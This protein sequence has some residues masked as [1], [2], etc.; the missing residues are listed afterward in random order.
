MQPQFTRTCVWVKTQVM[1]VIVTIEGGFDV[2]SVNGA[3]GA[4]RRVSVLLGIGIFLLPIIFVWFL[5]RRGYSVTARVIGFGWLALCIVASVLS[6]GATPSLQA[7]GG[8]EPKTAQADFDRV[9]ANFVA[10]VQPCE[11][12]WT[13][14]Q[15]ALKSGNVQDGYN[16]ATTAKTACMTA[17]TGVNSVKF[18]DAT[19]QPHRDKL[20]ND[21]NECSHAYLT[22][23]TA[24]SGIAE[25][26]NGDGKPSKVQ[27][28]Q[29]EIASANEKVTSCLT[30]Y[31]AD[32]KAAGMKLPG[33]KADKAANTGKGHKK[34]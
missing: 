12:G 4:P 5:L 8:A 15:P 19:P 3:S 26:L 21:L 16:I 9:N 31:A 30:N 34:T 14:V 23:A 32:A 18:G 27:Q 7:N 11:H 6:H 25:V 22:K 13:T 1:I 33:D 2:T 20:N 10:A 17:W 29:Y 24:L 28:V